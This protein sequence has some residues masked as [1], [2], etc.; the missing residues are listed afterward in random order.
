LIDINSADAINGIFELAG[1][2][3]CAFNVRRIWIDKIVRGVSWFSVAFF[4]A[5]G[6]WNLLYYPALGQTYS[7]LAGALLAFV[8]TI[9]VIL[10]IHYTRKENRAILKPK[11][12]LRNIE[13]N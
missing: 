8:N 12:K 7:F 9:W 1:A 2:F 5:W 4:A 6:W 10:L 11:T 13:L 3:A